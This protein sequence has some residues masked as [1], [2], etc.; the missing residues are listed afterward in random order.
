M[1]F[2]FF[3]NEVKRAMGIVLALPT[4]PINDPEAAVA[5]AVSKGC[6]I[7]GSSGSD[8]ISNIRLRVP[9]TCEG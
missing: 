7:V 2:A 6:G 4:G 5:E 1:R 8:R 9:H 3:T